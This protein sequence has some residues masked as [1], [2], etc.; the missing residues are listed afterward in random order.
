M[1]EYVFNAL[2]EAL[3]AARHWEM[4]YVLRPAEAAR[5]IGVSE[6]TLRRLYQDGK[7]P[8]VKFTDVKGGALGFRR[9]DLEEFVDSRAKYVLDEKA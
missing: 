7:L 2:M 3:D 5:H 1:N 6:S 8:C 4:R 9:K